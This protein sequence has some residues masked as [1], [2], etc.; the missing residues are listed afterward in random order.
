MTKVV[1]FSTEQVEP[2]QPI[3]FSEDAHAKLLV[4]Q[5]GGNLVY[6]QELRTWFQYNGT[7][8][9][10][11]SELEMV[12]SARIMNRGLANTI[13]KEANKETRLKKQLSSRRFSREVEAYARGEERC[14]LA[15]EELDADPWLLGTPGGIIDLRA[16]GY[17]AKGQKPYVTMVTAVAPADKADCPQFLEFMDEFTCGMQN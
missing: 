10:A 8:W 2:E 5:Y 1:P 12:E 3:K 14:L 16:G 9:Q 17:I 15:L 7:Y 6:V 4:D 11:V 13:T